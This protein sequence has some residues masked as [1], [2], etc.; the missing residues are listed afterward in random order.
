MYHVLVK[1]VEQVPQVYVVEYR[2]FFLRFNDDLSFYLV[3]RKAKQNQPEVGAI[4]SSP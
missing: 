4:F 1:M 2:E 3:R